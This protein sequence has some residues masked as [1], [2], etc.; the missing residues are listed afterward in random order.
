MIKI[1]ARNSN[2][3]CTTI[4]LIN[5][6]N[7][8]NARRLEC[9]F[10]AP[11]NWHLGKCRAE[12]LSKFRIGFGDKIIVHGFD[13]GSIYDLLDMQEIVA[14]RHKGYGK[15]RN[16]KIELFHFL[17]PFRWIFWPLLRSNKFILA[18]HND[19]TET[20]TSKLFS[21]YDKIQF[22]SPKQAERF[23]GKKKFFVCPN[24]IKTLVP[25]E[26]KPKDVAGI[27]ANIHPDNHIEDAIAFALSDNMKKIILF[28]DMIDTVYFY[29][30]IE[31][32]MKIYP[33]VRYAGFCEDMQIIYNSISNVYAVVPNR[34]W[35]ALQKECEMTN[36]KFIG[37]APDIEYLSENEIF[38]IWQ[39]ELR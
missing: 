33:Q 20:L 5:L 39:K 19:T 8:L 18:Y 37:Q 38:K 11:D 30:K 31:P 7:L 21:F 4:S 12:L 14:P 1:I 26:N 36:T 35:S 23:K 13:L 3:T 6:T 32:L 25:F 16:F 15:L 2:P 27:I 34:T 29:G 22:I 17:K 28:G 9:V 24:V 10:Y